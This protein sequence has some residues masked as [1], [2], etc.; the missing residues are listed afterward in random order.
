MLRF[1]FDDFSRATRS[2]TLAQATAQTQP[3]LRAARDLLA[4]AMPMIQGQGLTLIGIS[5]GNLDDDAA[6]Q[7]VLPFDRHGD[8]ALDAALDHV[9]ERFGS[10]ALGRAVLMDVDLG[11]SVP[12]LPD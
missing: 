5:V 7:L 2:H 8:G 3:I 9:R 11:L 6:V 1:R 4:A 12:M 10:K